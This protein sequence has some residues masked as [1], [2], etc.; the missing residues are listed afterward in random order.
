VRNAYK[1]LSRKPERS[2]LLGRPK[3]RRKDLERFV[4]CL[5]AIGY[6]AMMSMCDHSNEPLGT[7]TNSME[8]SPSEAT[9]HLAVEEFPNIVWNLK[10]YYHVHKYLSQVLIL[11]YID[12]VYTTPSCLL[13]SIIILPPTHRYS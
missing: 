13:R 6:R 7:I 9:S 5:F 12:P 8:L 10:V 3:C 11:S 1:F 4:L 2:R